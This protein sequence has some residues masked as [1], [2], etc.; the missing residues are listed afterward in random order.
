MAEVRVVGQDIVIVGTFHRVR[1]TRVHLQTEAKP[2]TVQAPKILRAARMLAVAHTLSARLGV[3]EFTDFTDMAQR[4]GLSR[5]RIT[6][7]VN[8]TFL[9]PDIQEEILWMRSPVGDD[10]ITEH[11]L[12]TIAAQGVWEVQRQLWKKLKERSSRA[13]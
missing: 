10:R 11:E 7:L 2:V 3:G 12:R 9:A 13:N 6:Q 4:F 5:A 8:L 1:K